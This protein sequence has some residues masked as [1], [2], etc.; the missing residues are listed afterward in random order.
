MTRREREV[1]GR[2]DAEAGGLAATPMRDEPTELG[3]GPRIGRRYGGW[4]WLWLWA[5][6]A[7][8]GVLR[9]A[10]GS[11]GPGWPSGEVGWLIVELRAQRLLVGATA[12]VALAA[13][14][15][16]LQALLRNELA[17]P[18]ILGL[19]TGAATGMVGQRLVVAAIGGSGVL[20][21]GDGLGAALGA[22][23]SMAVVYAAGRRRGVVDPLGLLLAGVVLSTI[24]GAIIMLAVHLFPGLLQVE[25]S[26][27]MMGYLAVGSVGNG[28]W[29]A[30][31]LATGG[32]VAWL[33]WRSPSMD[34]ATL[35]EREAASLGVAVG[36][37]RGELFVVA[38]L[39]AAGAVVLAGPVAFVGLIC[40]HIARWRVGPGHRPTLIGSAG[41]GAA[42]V[43]L[44]D[45]AG[46]GVA[47]AGGVGVVP[48][49]VFTAVVGGVGF[50][51]MLRPQL[52][53]GLG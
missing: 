12:G 27:W 22:G 20:W 21:W 18:F 32:G 5:A 8:A 30:V 28:V 3:S 11:E 13:A 34:V 42:L 51:W 43:W 15:V 44:A 10:V 14:G 16:A 2:V 49:G 46:A 33:V 41:L 47:W 29:L 17:E 35:S 37:L 7:G 26:Q 23:I 52:G 45:A 25:L 39:L 50:L 9:L 19:S 38:T 48:I 6:V 31:T 40:P 24:N 53:R 4:G 36:R 1:A